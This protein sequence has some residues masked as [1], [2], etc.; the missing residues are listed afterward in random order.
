MNEFFQFLI[1]VLKVFTGG[2][3]GGIL[4][5]LFKTQIDHRLAIARIYETAR[6]TEFSKAAATFRSRV[7]SELKGLY[8]LPRKWDA[9]T[10]QRFPQ[11]ITEI[12]SAAFEFRFFVTRKREF[13]SAI[14]EYCEYCEQISFEECTGWYSSDLE[15]RGG[16]APIEKF[17][18]L[19]KSLLSFAEEI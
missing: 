3:I 7:F 10:F 13:D 11:S 6:V 15:S 2:I 19:V 4:G 18:H 17:E 16:I 8:P 9:D 14:K 12:E 1:D 5:Y